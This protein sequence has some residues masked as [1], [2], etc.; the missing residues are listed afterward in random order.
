MIAEGTGAGFG[1]GIGRETQR[2]HGDHLRLL[3]LIVDPFGQRGGQRSIRH[4]V[5]DQQAERDEPD[6][7]D[8]QSRPQGHAQAFG[9]RST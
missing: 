4:E 9:G 7:D 1:P 5:G 8:Q 3:Q 2:A 6:R